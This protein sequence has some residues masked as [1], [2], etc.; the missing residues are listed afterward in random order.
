MSCASGACSPLSTTTGF[1]AARIASSPSCQERSPPRSRTT[2]SSTPSRRPFR[3]A[4]GSREGLANRYATGPPAARALSRSVSECDSSRSMARQALPRGC[5][6]PG[7]SCVRREFLTHRP[8]GAGPAHS[9][10]TAPESHRASS[11]GSWDPMPLCILDRALRGLEGAGGS[12]GSH[13]ARGRDG[14]SAPEIRATARHVPR[15]RARPT[16]T[17]PPGARPTGPP[18]RRAGKPAA[19]SP[20]ESRKTCCRIPAEE[21]GDRPAPPPEGVR[22]TG[23]SPPGARP[24]DRHTP[25]GQPVAAP[26]SEARPTARHVPAGEPASPPPR[27][28]R[29]TGQPVRAPRPGVPSQAGHTPPTAGFPWV[30]SP[31]CRPPRPRPRRPPR[32]TPCA[33]AR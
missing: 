24:A 13:R 18:C 21:P 2:T 3:S 22:P 32:R 27:P 23:T 10:G 28:R 11:P 19:A 1:P 7:W 29:K 33:G 17:S 6:R 30:C 5:P 16:G 31:P 26:P 4:S 12:G 9:G 20:P 15:R 25:A 14:A 8:G